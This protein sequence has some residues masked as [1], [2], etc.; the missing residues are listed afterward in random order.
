MKDG[1][2]MIILIC[3]FDVYGILFDVSVVVWV[4]VL[5]FENVEFVDIWL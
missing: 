1:G 4:V 3:I 5:E 2:D